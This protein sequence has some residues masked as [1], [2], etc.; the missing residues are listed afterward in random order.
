[1]ITQAEKDAA[2]TEKKELSENPEDPRTNESLRSEILDRFKYASKHFKEWDELAREDMAFGL[3][4]QWTSEDL[5]VLKDAGRPALTFNRIKPIISIV[6]GYQRENSSRIKVNPE[7]GEDRI[8]S[9]V[10]D[11]VFKHVDKVS[12][13][14]YKMSYWFDDGLYTG[15][16]WL[17]AV[18][19][20][21]N[22]PIRGELRFLQRTPYQILVDPDFNEY[23]LNEWPRGQYVFKIVR[24][25]RDVLKEIYPDHAALIQGFKADSDDIIENGSA[26]MYE[27]GKDDYGNRPNVASVTQK[28]D[29]DTESGLVRDNKFTVKEYWRPKMVDRFFVVDKE[30]GEPKK[31]NTNEEAEAF[32]T[33]QN[34][35]L[36]PSMQLKVVKRKVIEMWVAAMVGGFILQDDK[37]PF[38]PHYSGYP[39]F[40]FL[41]DWEPSAEDEKLRVQGIVRPLKDPQRE[42]N[43]SKSQNLHILNTQAN[44]GWIGDEDALTPEG[45]KQLEKMGSKPGIT[46]KKKKNSDLREILPKGPNQG[47]L[48]REQQAD[49]EFKQISAVNPDLMGMQEGTESGRAIAMRVR[50]AVLALVRIFHNYRYSKEIIGKFILEMFP[51]LFDEKKLGKVIGQQYMKNA[52]DPQ[53]YPEGLTE[54]H[55]KAFLTM[56][57]DNKY[58]V[59]VSEADQNKTIRF[60]IFQDLLELA[61]IRPEIPVELLIDY[62]DIGNSEEVKKKIREQQA[63]ALQAAQ[64]QQQ[65]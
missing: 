59:F 3:G 10:M 51:A 33:Q 57:K 38:E 12:H 20:Y 27:G 2:R 5:Q 26:V 42:K 29:E 52:V 1:M 45:W 49:A 11:R 56:V 34:T 44:S 48:M 61:K 32:L 22:D 43:K 24:L 40:R 41:S 25:T 36:D 46:V 7:G 55:L 15:K 37:S 53:Q 19:T 4:D 54:G 64:A 28:K 18:M 31:F 14:G 8:F 65:Q 17:E 47:H 23:D 50:Q 62:M 21:E 6:S 9:E 30:S 58:D 39:F 35:G 60:E 16:G 13:L 63:M